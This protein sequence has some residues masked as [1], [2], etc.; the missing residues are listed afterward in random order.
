[1]FFSFFKSF[2]KGGDLGRLEK[3]VAGNKEGKD[4]AV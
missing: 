2:M 4:L 1:M 3:R